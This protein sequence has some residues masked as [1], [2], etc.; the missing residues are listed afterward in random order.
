M[1]KRLFFALW[2]DADTRQR[3]VAVTRQLEGYGRA[4][5][6]NNIHVT[7]L[8]LGQTDSDQQ[9]SLSQR[10]AKIAVEPMNLSFDRLSYWPKPAVCCLTSRVFD[11][12]VLH[13][14]EQLR[15]AAQT[16]GMPV[17]QRVYQP[18]VTLLRKSRPTTALPVI[19][20]I[21]WQAERFCLVE[22]CSLP[23]GVEYRLVA[24]W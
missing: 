4:V 3:C 6:A 23:G 11:P 19:T 10:A 13:L 22:S 5:A 16:I 14:V 12:S 2:P 18:H 8:F 15:H 1:L 21:R 9:Q 24:R 17:E 20:P 7:L